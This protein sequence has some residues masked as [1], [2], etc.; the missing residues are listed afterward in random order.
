MTKLSNLA[1]P[2]S[3]T[4]K[5]I[6]DLVIK[7]IYDIR[8]NTRPVK[9]DPKEIEDMKKEKEDIEA[10]LKKELEADIGKYNDAFKSTLKEIT[11]YE[12]RV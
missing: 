8:P 5:E 6:T 7:T 3:L 4:D 11:G 2:T 9:Q 1:K 10:K 12:S